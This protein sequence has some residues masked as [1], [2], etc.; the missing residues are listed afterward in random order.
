MMQQ[1]QRRKCNVVPTCY[2]TNYL[3]ALYM[4]SR[5]EWKHIVVISTSIRVFS[6]AVCD[7][8]QPR[9]IVLNGHLRVHPISNLSADYLVSKPVTNLLGYQTV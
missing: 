4:V 3:F 1:L 7:H 8:R 9:A 5:T 6:S 2:D